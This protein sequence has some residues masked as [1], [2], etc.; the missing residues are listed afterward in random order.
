MENNSLRPATLKVNIPFCVHRCEFCTR[1]LIGGR[2]T[3][4]LHFYA[5]ALQKE[6]LANAAEFADCE[7]TA[8]HFGGG[9]ASTLTGSDFWLLTKALRE[10]YRI[11]DDAP[12]TM[13][14]T[15]LDINSGSL[16]FHRRA[17]IR[18]YDYE[19]MSLE[20]RD[21]PRLSYPGT[22]G[23]LQDVSNVTHA[24]RLH[25]MGFV[26][27]YGKQ[28]I[29]PANFRHSLLAAA[30]SHACHVILQRYEGQ[31]APEKDAEAAARIEEARA[32][33]PEYGFREYL[34]LRFAREG[35]EDRYAQ[36]RAAGMDHIAF[37]MGAVSCFDG[38]QSVN[39]M[40]LKTYF[41]HSGEFDKIVVEAKPCQT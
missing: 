36:N 35:C 32:L 37:G 24:A 6:I 38:V 9:M 25:N 18:R 7:I 11:A 39:T 19:V 3:E 27:L 14:A 1:P 17:G 26:L 40:D 34:P 10:N 16:P 21:F 12:V 2:D 22:L 8:I 33:L 30:R 13:R 15:F 5:L 28:S 23:W 20:P 31:D 41:L 4:R 29:T